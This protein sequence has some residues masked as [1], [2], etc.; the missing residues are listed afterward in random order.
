M[1]NDEKEALLGYFEFTL[2]QMVEELE[3]EK[4]ING[5]PQ[6]GKVYDAAYEALN[7]MERLI[8][9]NIELRTLEQSKNA[10]R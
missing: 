9:E 8:T 4:I 10:K 2:T 7:E 1:T 3:T 6:V 5:S